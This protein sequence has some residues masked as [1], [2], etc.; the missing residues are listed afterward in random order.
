MS[1]DDMQVIMCRILAELYRCMKMGI[2]PTEGIVGPDALGIGHG[3]W[4][5]IMAEL[6]DNGL[7]KGGTM[8]KDM[9]H[10]PIDFDVEGAS[11]TYQGVCFLQEDAG[12]RKALQYLKDIGTVAPAITALFGLL[13]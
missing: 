4:M 1:A 12:M 7:I 10:A 2:P 9:N 5:A 11:I 13:A 6:A 3:Y 8:M